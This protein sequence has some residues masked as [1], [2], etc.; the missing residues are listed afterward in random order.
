MTGEHLVLKLVPREDPM[1]E[2]LLRFRVDLYRDY[3]LDTC[4]RVF[5]ERF[6]VL[7]TLPMRDSPRTLLVLR[8]RA[9]GSS[10]TWQRA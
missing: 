10:E 2:R 9:S 6:E 8:K 4:R 1:F 5:E 7:E 3:N